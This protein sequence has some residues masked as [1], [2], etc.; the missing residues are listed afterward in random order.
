MS[1]L[2]G[3]RK[4]GR[5]GGKP[6]RA[7][8]EGEGGVGFG[9]LRQRMAGAC[10]GRPDDCKCDARAGVTCRNFTSKWAI[11]IEI[12]KDACVRLSCYDERRSSRRGGGRGG[13]GPDAELQTLSHANHIAHWIHTQ[14]GA[15][16]VV[17][18]AVEVA[19]A[20]TA[21][22]A[23]TTVTSVCQRHRINR[24]ERP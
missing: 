5:E 24:R 7:N 15:V 9:D 10:G 20:V 21:T 11:D 19:T 8:D 2:H 13:K 6:A 16:A 4:G 22:A 14:A 23:A 1:C 18:A 12:G 17:S 3:G